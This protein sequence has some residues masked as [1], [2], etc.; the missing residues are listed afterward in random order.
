MHN[1]LV[2][3]LVSQGAIGIAIVL[4]LI[5]VVVVQLW[6]YAFFAEGKDYIDFVYGLACIAAIFVSMMFYSETFYMNTG[7]AFLFWYLLG[8]IVNYNIRILGAKGFKE[9]ISKHGD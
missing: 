2:D 1:F 9:G 8:Y 3:I 4:V 5:A 6:K 7:G